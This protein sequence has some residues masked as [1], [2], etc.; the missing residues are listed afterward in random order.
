MTVE[1]ATT[2]D[3]ASLEMNA[4]GDKFRVG[5]VVGKPGQLA[6]P[7]K[8]EVAKGGA[9][10]ATRKRV[11]LIEGANVTITAA[12]NAGGDRVDLTIASTVTG[13]AVYKDSSFVRLAADQSTTSTTFVDVPTMTLLPTV[14]TGDVLIVSVSGSGST[15]AA[16]I[17]DLSLVVDGTTAVGASMDAL[18]SPFPF[19]WALTARL[20]GLVAGAHTIKLQ[21]RTSA[22]T[23][24]VR[25]V[26]A[27]ATEHLALL[28]ERVT[29]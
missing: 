20:T 9:L 22:N 2:F 24:R 25:P 23:L 3:D 19:C 12:D 1:L 26:T 13:G 27:L 14:E 5:N 10:V 16:A 21:W 7:Q 4:T 29:A 17:V 6:D 11:N 28:I 18:V 8:L 15:I